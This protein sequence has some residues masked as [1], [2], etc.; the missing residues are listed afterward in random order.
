MILWTQW[1]C[2]TVYVLQNDKSFIKKVVVFPFV[3]YLVYR[4][5]IYRSHIEMKG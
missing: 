1:I 3:Q 5:G 4:V 2:Y